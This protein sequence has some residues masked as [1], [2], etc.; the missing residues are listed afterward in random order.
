MQDNEERRLFYVGVTRARDYLVFGSKNTSRGQEEYNIPNLVDS[1]IA[2]SELGEGEYNDRFEWKGEK[3]KYEKREYNSVDEAFF[4]NKQKEVEHGYYGEEEPQRGEYELVKNNP[5]MEGRAEG[6]TVER[7]LDLGERMEGTGGKELGVMIHRVICAYQ[8]E[9]GEAENMTMIRGYL[10]EYGM[11][12]MDANKLLNSIERLIEYIGDGEVLREYPLQWIT[13]DGSMVNG[14]VDLL[15]RRKDGVEIVD[16][17]TMHVKDIET[18]AL[19]YS[20]QLKKYGDMVEQA[21]REK[22]KKYGIYFV[23]EGK[24]VEIK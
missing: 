21:I 5:S 9:L 22:V 20:G 13:E 7:V 23:M 1:R 11:E 6:M 17:K 8:Q 2:V 12:R 3:I 18:K 10:E 15:I 24:M 16:Y 4:E 14:T 19:E